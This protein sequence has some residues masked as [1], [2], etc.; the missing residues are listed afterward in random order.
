MSTPM[1]MDVWSFT[2]WMSVMSNSL[3]TLFFLELLDLELELS[4]HR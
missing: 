3:I 2:F 4:K 1:D